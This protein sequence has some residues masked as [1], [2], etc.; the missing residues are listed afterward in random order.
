LA[1]QDNP[2]VATEA[3][4]AA[5]RAHGNQVRAIIMKECGL[6]DAA[7]KVLAVFLHGQ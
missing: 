4:C 2:E 5:L 3:I 1:I 7:V 6:T